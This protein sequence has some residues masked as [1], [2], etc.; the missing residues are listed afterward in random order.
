L[1]TSYKLA[2]VGGYFDAA[3]QPANF[4]S[5]MKGAIDALDLTKLPSATIKKFGATSVADLHIKI[6][7]NIN[8]I[9]S[10]F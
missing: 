5:K 8:S 2:A 6:D 7:K 4:T 10:L 1:A 3:K 9:F